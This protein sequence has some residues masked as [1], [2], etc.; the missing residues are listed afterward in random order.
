[1]SIIAAQIEHLTRKL[2][3][4]TRLVAVSKFHTVAAIMEAYNAGQRIFG[5]NKVQELVEKQSILPA[6]IAWHF[7]GH[8]QTNKVKYI[9]TFVDLIHSIDTWKLL[10]EVNR[11]AAKTGRT[12][13]VLLQIHI[14]RETS[15]SGLSFDEC[16]QLLDGNEWKTRSHIQI[17]G[18][19][20]MATFTDDEDLICREFQSLSAFFREIKQKHFSREPSFCELSMG[21]SDDYSLA[22]EYG[23]T[24]VRI[25]SLIFGTRKR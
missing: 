3:P 14:A 5:E 4:Q 17:C 22:L 25:G 1:M 12:I 9:A 15:K 21:M 18:L 11:Q 6:D 2:P 24:L 7:I 8:L 19:M 13:R 23:S 20:G 10:E 16:R